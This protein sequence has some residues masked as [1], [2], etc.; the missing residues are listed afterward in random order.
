ML[1]THFTT[2]MFLSLLWFTLYGKYHL[3]NVE[4]SH[5]CN[6]QCLLWAWYYNL[7]SIIYHPID[8]NHIYEA[9]IWKITKQGRGLPVVSAWTTNNGVANCACHFPVTWLGIE[10]SFIYLLCSDVKAVILELF[11]SADIIK[12]HKKSPITHHLPNLKQKEM[13]KFM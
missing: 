11:M 10:R 4:T 2:K 5:N 6:R 1:K 8:S 13:E 3:F 9:L 12:P 7:F